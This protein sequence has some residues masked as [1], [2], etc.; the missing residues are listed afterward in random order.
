M[1]LTKA[2]LT[3]LITLL[4]LNSFGKD[5]DLLT[6][7]DAKT[8]VDINKMENLITEIN[9]AIDTRKCSVEIKV[10]DMPKNYKEILKLNGYKVEYYEFAKVDH[11][12]W[13][14]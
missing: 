14:D 1:R 4:S 6:A 2:Y 10:V 3:I 8:M 9:L 12:S 5:V 13:C 7:K 11:I